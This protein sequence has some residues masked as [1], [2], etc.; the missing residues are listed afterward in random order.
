MEIVCSLCTGVTK[1]MLDSFQISLRSPCNLVNDQVRND[2][3]FLRYNKFLN[4]FKPSRRRQITHLGCSSKRICVS[5]FLR[6]N[7]NEVNKQCAESFISLVCV[8]LNV[9]PQYATSSSRKF[10]LEPQ[11][12]CKASGRGTIL[13]LCRWYVLSLNLWGHGSARATCTCV[14]KILSMSYNH[15]Q[16]LSVLMNSVG[17]DG[18]WATVQDHDDSLTFS[19]GQGSIKTDTGCL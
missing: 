3:N 16:S 12:M 10:G 4:C 17:S 11:L 19:V 8:G 7:V 18:L 9:C 13:Q 6:S 15:L 5:Q 1:P 2:I 14:H